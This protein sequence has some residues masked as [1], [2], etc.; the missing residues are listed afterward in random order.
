MKH[1]CGNLDTGS[2]VD[3]MGSRDDDKEY[4]DDDTGS[5]LPLLSSEIPISF[6][7]DESI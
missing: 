1:K 4:G 5:L 3:D 7:H 2:W 6:D